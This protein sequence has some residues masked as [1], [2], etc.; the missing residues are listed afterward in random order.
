MA[1]GFN[2]PVVNHAGCTNYAQG[3]SRVTSPYGP[4]NIAL[5][6]PGNAVGQLTV[7]VVTQIANHLATVGGAFSGN[8]IVTVMAGGNDG[9]IQTLTYVG[10]VAN[11]VPP[12]NAAALVTN[13]MTTAANE[14][15]ALI[16]TQILAKGAKYVVVVNLPNQALTPFAS[17][18]E[19]TLPVTRSTVSALTIAF[20]TAL[21]SG[22]SGVANVTLVDA[23]TAITDQINNKAAYGLTNVT[24]T[25]CNLASPGNAIGSSLVCNASNLN[26]GDVSHYLFADSVHPTPYGYQQ[27]AELVSKGLV[28]S[29]WL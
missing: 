27:L 8:E 15:V 2:V 21:A 22:L 3:G 24:G 6:A 19:A 5:G 13:N 11:S 26:T 23:Y 14:L 4:Y 12:A 9:I 25:A 18:E 29:G 20:N 7:P 16:K 10:A 1:P 17:V 28:F